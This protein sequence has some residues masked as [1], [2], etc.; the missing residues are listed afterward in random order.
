MSASCRVSVDSASHASVNACR[1]G[2]SPA[3]HAG[4]SASCLVTANP[5]RTPPV[6]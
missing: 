6:P 3:D 5:E 2:A 1:V 4:V